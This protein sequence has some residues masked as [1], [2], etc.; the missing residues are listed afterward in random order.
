MNTFD[1]VVL[2]LI[3]A[4]GIAG[5][6]KGLIMGLS[7]LV[8]KIAAIV[9]AVVFHQ[10]FLKTIEPVLGL[11]K[12]IEPKI[13]GFLAKIVESKL[14]ASGVPGGTTKAL[15]QPAIN[16]AT[17]A[18]T[19]YVLKIGSLLLL[20][21]LV[22][23]IINFVISL[24]ISPVAKSLSFADRGGGMIFGILSTLIGVCL[25][26]GLVA[27][28]LTKGNVGLF[29]ISNSILY[30]WLMEGYDFILFGIKAY[31][32]DVLKNPLE[33]IPLFKGMQV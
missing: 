16:Q 25:F 1:I 31:A 23:L 5:F 20:F 18:L 10:Q 22:S 11:K 21:I 2:I 27:P 6:Q 15:A 29:K 4:G 9:V 8:G 30:P 7:R 13:S 19:D 26:V 24:I 12:I 28:L 33:G 3:L 17:V 14:A 32:G